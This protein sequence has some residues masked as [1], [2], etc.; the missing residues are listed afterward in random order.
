MIRLYASG[1]S[2]EID[3]INQ[4]MRPEVWTR[5]RD[6]AA[7]LLTRRGYDRAAELLRA[8]PFEL[9]E[10]T[11]SF[12]DEFSLLYASL[13]LEQ[14][15]ALADMEH[16]DQARAY[17]RQIA[18]ALAE[19]DVHVRFIAAALDERAEPTAV[20]A[21]APVRTSQ[22]LERALG[23]VERSLAEGQPAT[24]VDRVH[25]AFHAYLRELATSI[26]HDSGDAGIVELFRTLR[27]SHPALQATGPRAADITRIL[28]AMATV[29][30]ALNPLRN[31]ASLAHPAEGLLADAEAML[32]I[33]AVRTLLH[34]FEKKVR[35]PAP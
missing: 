16:D 5:L 11:N 12:G 26:G 33:N 25:T 30:D 15:I 18:S 7:R 35:E 6:T 23:E 22:T 20:A 21:P 8:T 27:Q 31:R 1:G 19:T 9:W 17:F 4:R 13:P 28:N 2:Q 10:G 32:V 3:L 29:V 24:G 34:Y 14:Y